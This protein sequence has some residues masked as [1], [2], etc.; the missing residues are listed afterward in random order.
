MTLLWRDRDWFRITRKSNTANV[1]IIATH[2]DHWPVCPVPRGRQYIGLAISPHPGQP[3]SLV[4]IRG[5]VCRVQTFMFSHLEWNTNAD[6]LL[7]LPASILRNLC[8]LNWNSVL[9]L[10]LYYYDIINNQH[11]L[12]GNT[13]L[14]PHID[15]ALHVFKTE[16]STP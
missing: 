5:V 2:C 12:T 6:L 15:Q 3:R 11:I 14:T 13:H 7:L 9:T 16:V 1:A 8:K 4:T 10:L